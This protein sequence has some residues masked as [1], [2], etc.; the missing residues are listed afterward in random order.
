MT[1]LGLRLREL[2]AQKGLT[3]R[4]LAELIDKTPGYVSRFETRDEIPSGELLCQLA[5]IYAVAPDELLELA[6]QAHLKR[7]AADLDERY[8]ATLALYRKQVR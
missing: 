3:V 7:T 5:D 8:Q 1:T 4:E 2:R 6:K